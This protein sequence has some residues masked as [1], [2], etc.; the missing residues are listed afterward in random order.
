M[1]V[2]YHMIR[3][4]PL[5]I[6]IIFILKLFYR[7]AP[8]YINLSWLEVFFLARENSSRCIFLNVSSIHSNNALIHFQLEVFSILLCCRS[9][10]G[11]LV[12][13]SLTC[14]TSVNNPKYSSFGNSCLQYTSMISRLTYHQSIEAYS[15]SLALSRYLHIMQ[16]HLG[17]GS[18]YH[19]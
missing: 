12:I 11:Y 14:A 1:V 17:C 4:G 2:E 19:S 7:F 8:F 6:K 5:Y 13:P 16:T 9:V 18:Q 3:H 10:I 15:S